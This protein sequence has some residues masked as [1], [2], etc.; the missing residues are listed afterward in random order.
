MHNCTSPKEEKSFQIKL[1]NSG[2]E[3]EMSHYFQ[4]LKFKPSPEF[5]PAVASEQKN[6]NKLNSNCFPIRAAHLNS[7]VIPEIFN[8]QE[9]VSLSLHLTERKGSVDD[10]DLGPSKLR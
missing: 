9:V 2:I 8:Q 7:C 5:S 6:Y 4:Q 3:H 10:E 1:F